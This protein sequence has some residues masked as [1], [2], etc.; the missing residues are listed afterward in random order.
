MVSGVI[1]NKIGKRWIGIISRLLQSN[2]P[3]PKYATGKLVRSL[4]F[5]HFKDADGNT[6]IQLISAKS[7]K[8][9]EYI[10]VIDQGRKPG[11]YVPINALKNWAKVKGIP[12]EAVYAINKKIFKDGIKATFIINRSLEQLFSSQNK[13]LFDEI[14]EEVISDITKIFK[15]TLTFKKV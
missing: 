10:K 3:F 9:F 4:Q 8:G 13:D 15:N 7:D 5:K 2:L 12:E 14:E 6:V 11:K 1:L